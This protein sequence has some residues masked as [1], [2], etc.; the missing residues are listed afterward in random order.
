LF[1]IA[2]EFKID[3][4]NIE[5][6]SIFD[7]W[8]YVNHTNK[9]ANKFLF[10]LYLFALKRK[11]FL[12]IFADSSFG[13]TGVAN[14]L[15]NLI[16]TDYYIHI[17]NIRSYAGLRNILYKDLIVIDE[18]LRLE[19][20]EL[21]QVCFC[22]LNVADF[23]DVY[24]ADK[25]LGF[26]KIDISKTSIITL[27]NQYT[28]DMYDER[29]LSIYPDVGNRFL[30]VKLNGTFKGFKD[31]DKI[32]MEEYLGYAKRIKRF[33]NTNVDDAKIEF[34]KGKDYRAF[35]SLANI[36]YC[37]NELAIVEGWDV[38]YV[39]EVWNK[40]L[41]NYVEDTFEFNYK[42]SNTI[43]SGGDGEWVDTMI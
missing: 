4:E 32:T 23:R 37:F 8:N 36:F 5:E 9:E 6:K 35:L 41:E 3:F 25:S 42:W 31:L 21:K 33:L 28:Q 15:R 26:D 10:L 38:F 16:F 24:D 17:A 2:E 40:F 18:F 43:R 11:M 27:I 19:D 20:S 13:K 29:V 22:L 30:Y 1:F 14:L 34:K 7:I 39:D 12:N